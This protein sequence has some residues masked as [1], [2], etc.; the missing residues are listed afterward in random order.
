MR[1]TATHNELELLIDLRDD[2]ISIG[3][4]NDRTWMNELASVYRTKEY[5]REKDSIVWDC[6]R[7]G[8]SGINT[9]LLEKLTV[10]QK[11]LVLA[12]RLKEVMDC[13]DDSMFDKWLAELEME[14]G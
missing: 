13:E 3:I 8:Q 14:E 2:Y 1:Y 12:I 11:A 9:T 10:R 6:A 4:Y 7:V 5:N